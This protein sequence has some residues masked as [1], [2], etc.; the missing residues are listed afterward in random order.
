MVY[1]RRPRRLFNEVRALVP[2]LDGAAA[3]N[4]ASATTPRIHRSGARYRGPEAAAPDVLAAADLVAA[5]P[6]GRSTADIV[7]QRLRPINGI[8]REM[9]YCSCAISSPSSIE[10]MQ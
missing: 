2:A 7:H 10:R 8:D 4:K 3:A 6:L 1:F 9:Q 5:A